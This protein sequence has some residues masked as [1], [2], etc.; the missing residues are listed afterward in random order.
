MWKNLSEE[1]RL[2]WVESVLERLNDIWG[3]KKLSLA[4]NDGEFVFDIAPST[5]SSWKTLGR[6]KMP[7]AEVLETS[8]LKGVSLDYIF[9]GKEIEE[10]N[11][12]KTYTDD[13]I[14]NAILVLSDLG[15]IESNNSRIAYNV[16][17]RELDN[18]K[19]TTNYKVS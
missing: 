7:W 6:V 2:K 5:Y 14:A 13:Q 1:A 10:I 17:M 18:L 12:G 16:F 8:R 9:F 4:K 19:Q 3:V 15:L 11:S